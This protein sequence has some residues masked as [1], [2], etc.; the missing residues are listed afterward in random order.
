MQCSVRV[1]VRPNFHVR[2][3]AVEFA[4]VCVR[5]SCGA[6]VRVHLPR[7]YTDRAAANL[8]F[9]SVVLLLALLLH[10]FHSIFCVSTAAEV[11]ERSRCESVGACMGDWH[12]TTHASIA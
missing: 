5:L 6:I 3:R 12:S 8:L 1:R 2:V 4:L 10:S 7:F 9:P 11:D